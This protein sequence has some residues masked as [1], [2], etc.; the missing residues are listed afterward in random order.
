MSVHSRD[1]IVRF[2]HADV[3]IVGVAGAEGFAI[4]EYLLSLGFSRITGHNL[5]GEESLERAF[6]IAHVSLDRT[7]R[8]DALARLLHAPITLRTGVQYLHGIENA[9][10]VFAT[11]NWFAHRAN[12][13]LIALR[14]S[15]VPFCFITQLYL[16]LSPAPV[17][18]VTGTNGKTTVSTWL[19]HILTAA[20][21]P[22]L[23]SGNDRYHPQVLNRLDT[24]PANGVLVLEISNRQL[25]EI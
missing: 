5:A 9:D 24:L 11:Q 3:H 4:L 6:D 2:R 1:D 20:G 17:A 13:P 21:R 15:G 16:A 22:C 25:K 12:A 10:M 18:A 7:A 23:M 14:S 8:R 19:Y